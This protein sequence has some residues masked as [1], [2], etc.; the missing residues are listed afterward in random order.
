MPHHPDPVVPGGCTEPGAWYRGT[1]RLPA[2]TCVVLGVVVVA[3]GIR[4]GGRP[5]CATLDDHFSGTRGQE[6]LHAVVLA[7]V[8][9]FQH[10]RQLVLGGYEQVG[11]GQQR[12]E[13]GAGAVGGPQS[14]AVVDVEAY[15]DAGLA[16]GGRGGQGGL[17]SRRAEHRGD[18]GQMQDAGSRS[19]CGQDVGR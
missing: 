6:T 18:A 14:G 13:H 5:A 2:A 10:Q 11:A 3:A 4:P 8:G 9:P 7:Y 19:Q 12:P 17:G 15:G 1:T 16:G